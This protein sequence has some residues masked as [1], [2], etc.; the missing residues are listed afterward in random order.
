MPV[1]KYPFPNPSYPTITEIVPCREETYAFPHIIGYGGMPL[2]CP[3]SRKLANSRKT[4]AQWLMTS[5]TGAAHAGIPRCLVVGTVMSG[6]LIGILLARAV[7]GFWC[8]VLGWRA[9]YVLAAL[10][11]AGLAEGNSN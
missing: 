10:L 5:G 9:I 3:N 8:D 11:T 6:L 2:F 7:S 4:V 1:C